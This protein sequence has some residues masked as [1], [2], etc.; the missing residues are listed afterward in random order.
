M[1]LSGLGAVAGLSS[2]SLDALQ[3]GCQVD[4]VVLATSCRSQ[5]FFLQCEFIW[6]M[7]GLKNKYLRLGMVA[8]A[9]V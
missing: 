4:V 3:C 8:H 6:S 7:A 9:Y 2:S 5:E 1:S